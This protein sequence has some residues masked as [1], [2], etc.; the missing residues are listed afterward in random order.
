MSAPDRGDAETTPPL[1]RRTPLGGRTGVAVAS[2]A[3]VIALV[4]F[5]GV[6]FLASGWAW[7]V[8]F[9]LLIPVVYGV[10]SPGGG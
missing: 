8:I 3:P 9:F 2:I 6:G 7:C 1:T 4:L 10:R 5:F